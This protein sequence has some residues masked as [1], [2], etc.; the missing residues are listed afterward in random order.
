M[1]S[2]GV[3]DLE[4]YLYNE[5]KK[6]MDQLVKALNSLELRPKPKAYYLDTWV[7]NIDNFFK[8]LMV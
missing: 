4:K 2:R 5:R 3:E 6:D 1:S 7:C 8:I